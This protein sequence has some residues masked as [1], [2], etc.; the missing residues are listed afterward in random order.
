[1]KKAQIEQR[2]L[3]MR[4]IDYKKGFDSVQQSQLLRSIT[5]L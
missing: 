2:N 3:C 5:N 4:Y 1:M